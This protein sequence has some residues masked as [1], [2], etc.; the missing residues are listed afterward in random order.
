MKCMFY[1]LINFVVIL[2]CNYLELLNKKVW[3]KFKYL[4]KVYIPIKQ[5]DK[6]KS[7]VFYPIHIATEKVVATLPKV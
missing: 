3:L 7:S 4:Y 6:N 5:S 2:R 1:G